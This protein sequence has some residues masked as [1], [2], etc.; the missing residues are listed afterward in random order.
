[1]FR[2]VRGYVVVVPRPKHPYRSM[3]MNAFGSCGLRKTALGR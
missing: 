3:P 2:E 1:M